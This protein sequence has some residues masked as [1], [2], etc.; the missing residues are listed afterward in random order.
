MAG[1]GNLKFERQLQGYRAFRRRWFLFPTRE[2]GIGNWR[3]EIG[4]WEL[5]IG[6]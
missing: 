6:D 4:D 2:L 1:I 3:L 5:E